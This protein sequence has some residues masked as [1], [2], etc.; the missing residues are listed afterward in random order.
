M[1]V[2]THE[3]GRPTPWR[4]NWGARG[5]WTRETLK[6]F[7]SSRRFLSPGPLAQASSVILNRKSL[8][9]R[10]FPSKV[11]QDVVPRSLASLPWTLDALPE[12][13][14]GSGPGLVKGV[15]ILLAVAL[16][17]MSNLERET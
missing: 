8:D 11:S 7:V 3:N 17:K 2:K 5:W 6:A 14:P 15:G 4:T 16:D 12:T 10:V 13:V 9:Q 1:A